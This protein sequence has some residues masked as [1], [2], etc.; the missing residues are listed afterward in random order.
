MMRRKM[1][2]GRSKRSFRAGRRSHS[3][4]FRSAKRGGYRI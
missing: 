4:N 1:S 2:R 3:R